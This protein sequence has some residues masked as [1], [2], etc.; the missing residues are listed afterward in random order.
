[1]LLIL[2]G[3]THQVDIHYVRGPPFPTGPEHPDL[4]SAT[5]PQIP[6]G[7]CCRFPV[8]IP[9]EPR[10]LGRQMARQVRV[11]S[12]R[13]V[14]I[15][16]L[17]ALHI[18]AI[19]RAR[20]NV[21]DGRAYS[22]EGCSGSIMASRG[23]PGDWHWNADV[24]VPI[25]Y[26]RHDITGASWIQL[27][28]TLPPDTQT[29]KWMM[30]E[31]ILGLV[32]GGGKWFANEQ[33]QRAFGRVGGKSRRDIRS[34]EKGNVYSRAP[35]KGRYPSLIGIN[36]MQYTDGGRGDLIYQNN[37]GHALNLTNWF[38]VPKNP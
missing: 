5:C 32:W 1:M 3:L 31:G 11:Y 4:Q 18:A 13:E 14:Y 15:R 24:D 28:E 29:T 6:A 16:N 19:W 38:I 26:N 34:A 17:G 23:G 7:E 2:V 12:K 27:P 33:A 9:D 8:E 35:V 37:V 10:I 20:H 22:I 21:N 36:G 25:E 30:G